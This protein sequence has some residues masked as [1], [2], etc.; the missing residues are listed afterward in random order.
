MSLGARRTLVAV[1]LSI[2]VL[3]VIGLLFL[4]TLAQGRA[5]RTG[6]IVTQEVQAGASFSSSNVQQVHIPDAGDSFQILEQSPINHRAARQLS[7]QTL[8]RPD[9]VLS[10]T[11][12]RVTVSLRNSPPLNV[13][14]Q[15]D[16]YAQYQG[17]SLLVGRALTVVDTQPVV[18][19]VPAVQEQAWITLE[20]NDVSLYAAISPGLSEGSGG[21]EAA[22]DA[23][24]QL[25]A[26]ASGGGSGTNGGG[27]GGGGNP[28]PTPTASP[29][30]GG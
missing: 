23:I 18:L 7:A 19:L 20:A 3:A 27:S 2:V 15:I 4:Q 28:T 29:S 21:G 17:Q 25:A 10:Q 5:T 12:A 8:L 6:W 14:Q 9:D 22:G 11:T 24:Q 1:I 30:S 26:A 13:S 16:I